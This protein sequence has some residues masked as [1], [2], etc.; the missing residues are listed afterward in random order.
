M[1]ILTNTI[2]FVTRSVSLSYVTRMGSR[3]K[4]TAI[5]GDD[6]TF[7]KDAEK[8][9][10]Q[11]K[12]GRVTRLIHGGR[13]LLSAKVLFTGFPCDQLTQP[14]VSDTVHCFLLYSLHH[15]LGN[16]LVALYF[17][18]LFVLVID[19][20]MTDISSTDAYDAN[21]VSTSAPNALYHDDEIDATRDNTP[22]RQYPEQTARS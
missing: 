3:I 1:V 20:A 9:L 5:S 13:L 11:V 10:R 2:P 21:R 7:D 16:T 14:L 8:F 17:P 4:A 15:P 12:S 6:G 18:T 22:Q 19:Q